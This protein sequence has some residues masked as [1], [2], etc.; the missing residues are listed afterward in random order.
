M[1]PGATFETDGVGVR[2]VNASA[3]TVV[4]SSADNNCQ[5]ILWSVL[6]PGAGGASTA[7]PGLVWLFSDGASA[8]PTSSWVQTTEP[9]LW[10]IQ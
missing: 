6:L 5:V 10:V 8:T 3:S 4:V 7:V 1:A 9:T 2:F